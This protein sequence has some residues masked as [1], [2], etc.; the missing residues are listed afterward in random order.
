[1]STVGFIGE[2]CVQGG[3]ERCQFEGCVCKCHGGPI[4]VTLME[5]ID[6]FVERRKEKHGDIS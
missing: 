3:H 4:D 1:M 2:Q 5:R 6:E